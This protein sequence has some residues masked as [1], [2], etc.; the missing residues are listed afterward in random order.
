MALAVGGAFLKGSQPNGVFSR[1]RLAIGAV[2]AGCMFAVRFIWL[3]VEFVVP[4]KFYGDVDY[5]RAYVPQ[6]TVV[7]SLPEVYFELLDYDRFLSYRDGERYGILLRDEDYPTF[8]ERERP[9]VFVGE[10]KPDDDEWWAYM[11]AHDFRQVRDTVWIA[12]DLLVN[13]QRQ[14]PHSGNCHQG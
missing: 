8:W 14:P 1:E 7:M 10:P 3:A 9:Q 4:A 2:I 6:D 11:H 12:A 5:V 13:D